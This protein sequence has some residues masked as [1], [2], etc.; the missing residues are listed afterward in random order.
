[1]QIVETRNY[2]DKLESDDVI[3][4]TTDINNSLGYESSPKTK[5]VFTPQ[6]Q[7][8]NENK[9]FENF[10]EKSF[11]KNN[12]ENK[13]TTQGPLSIPK[14]SNNGTSSELTKINEIETDESL[15]LLV[16]EGPLMELPLNKTKYEEKS[17]NKLKNVTQILSNETIQPDD[18]IQSNDTLIEIKK[19]K[20]DKRKDQNRLNKTVSKK[21]RFMIT[22]EDHYKIFEINENKT[23]SD[24]DKKEVTKDFVPYVL[25]NSSGKSINESSQNFLKPFSIQS[26]Q[27]S[28]QSSPLALTV[29]CPLLII[30]FIIGLFIIKRVDLISKAKK[31]FA[32]KSDEKGLI[33]E[34]NKEEEILEFKQ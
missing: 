27:T 6:K 28:T 9:I 30:F 34:F 14:Q 31:F 15:S 16:T 10:K 18:N 4:E 26:M 3:E 13:K 21:E 7:F 22:N 29:I 11:Q 33:V 23:S 25:V 12:S 19:K 8:L 2:E 17:Q 5:I 24:A 32:K 20:K 1:M